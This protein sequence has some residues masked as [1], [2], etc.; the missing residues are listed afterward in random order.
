M[1]GAQSVPKSQSWQVYGRRDEGL[2]ILPYKSNGFPHGQ[3]ELEM[4][5]GGMMVISQQHFGCQD[6]GWFVVQGSALSNQ[7]L[8]SGKRTVSSRVA[9]VQ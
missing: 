5:R 8:L 1:R 7:T 2:L 4:I 9:A 3:A 6:Q